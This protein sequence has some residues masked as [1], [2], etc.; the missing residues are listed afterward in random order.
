[1]GERIAKVDNY[2]VILDIPP[3][4]RNGKTFIPLGFIS[5]AFGTLVKRNE[6]TKTV[7]ITSKFNIDPINEN[8]FETTYKSVVFKIGDSPKEIF[9]K[10]GI[11]RVEEDDRVDSLGYKSQLHIYSDNDES[12]EISANVKADEFTKD[13][14]I[15]VIDVTDYGTDRGVKKNCNRDDLIKVYGESTLRTGTLGQGWVYEYEDSKLFFIFMD[16]KIEAIFILG[17]WG[18]N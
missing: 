10:V 16:G 12:P 4:I 3:C 2:C 11:G 8:D 14:F 13:Q 15:S 17:K 9:E 7:E 1:M 5:N 18:L 6:I